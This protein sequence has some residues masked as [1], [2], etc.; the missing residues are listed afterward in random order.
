MRL[1]GVRFIPERCALFSFLFLSFSS[2]W[3][4]S[5]SLC[6]AHMPGFLNHDAYIQW[7]KKQ[8][9]KQSKTKQT[10][11]S[12]AFAT[13][14]HTYKMELAFLVFQVVKA[15][16]NMFLIE[17]EEAV[18]ANILSQASTEVVTQ[19]CWRPCWAECWKGEKNRRIMCGHYSLQAKSDYVSL[20][21]FVIW[22]SQ[23]FHLD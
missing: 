20:L 8:N 1:N 10:T 2:N 17:K 9:K 6:S 7:T 4:H 11:H 5:E 14:T 13:C 3:T 21:L 19:M 15:P 18:D 22:L 12:S 16:D 23:I